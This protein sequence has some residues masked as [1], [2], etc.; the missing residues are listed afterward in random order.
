M[1]LNPYYRCLAV[2][3]AFAVGG[4]VGV[5]GPASAEPSTPAAPETTPP[6]GWNSWNSGIPLNEQSVHETIDAMVSSGMRDAGYRYVN[7]DAGW[8][9]PHRDSDGTLQADPVLF[10]HGMAALADYAHDRGMLLGLYSSPFD[11]TCGQGVA[12]AGIGHETQDARQ[13]ADWGVD[14]LKYDWCRQ[15]A[16]H[17]EQVRVFTAMRDALRATGRHIVY[18]IN[19]NS[20]DDSDAGVR[21]DWSS[22][23]DSTRSTGDLIPVWRN[24]LP[25]ADIAG[26]DTRGF[27][28]VADELDAAARGQTSRPGYWSDPDMLVVGMSLPEF[29]GA[30]LE[31]VPDKAVKQGALSADQAEQLQLGRLLSLSPAELSAL[32]ERQSLS[33]TEQQA[34]LSLWAMLSAPLIAGNDVRTLS[35]RTRDMLTNRDVVAVD[36]DPAVAAAVRSPRDN[37]IWTKRLSDGSVAVAFFNTGDQPATLE[38]TAAEAGLPSATEY[39]VRN[40][41]TGATGASAGDLTAPEIPS[42]G[43]TMLRVAAAD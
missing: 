23:A 22:I 29:L 31:G 1:R 24:S 11:E 28:G 37:R 21:Y 20:S 7:L 30:H 25:A 15:G 10:P 8:T 26:I 36:Q 35:A 27:L 13:F 18:D 14:F 12:A 5:T 16:D 38:T 43:V 41:W 6:M 34:H 40:A 2:V 17:D 19:P 39:T 4:V 9:A 42:H 33:V 32:R 3:V